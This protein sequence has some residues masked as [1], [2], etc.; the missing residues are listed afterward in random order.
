MLLRTRLAW[1]AA[2]V[3]AVVPS[4]GPR[5]AAAPTVA[6]PLP[7]VAWR[8]VGPF[9]G[10]WSTM[11][12]GVPGL[13]DTYYAGTAGGGLWKSND[14]GR[15]WRA[16]SD[17]A[18]ITAVGALA[19][20][21]SDPSTLY[22]GTGQPEPRYDIGA[23][24]G[25]Y[26]SRDAGTSWESMGLKD[27]R[28]IGAL[29]VDRRD[30]NV[31]LV[32]ALGHAFGPGG[33]RG[34]YRSGD[35]GKSWERTLFVDDQTGA[36]DLA[37]D[38]LDPDLVFAATW[39]MRVWPWLSYFTPVE[40]PG[41][42]IYRSRDGGRTWQKLGGAGW[43]EGDLGR[44][45][46]AVTR[47]AGATRIYAAV[48]SNKHAGLYRSDD[49]GGHWT[50]VNDAAWATSW[51]V[52]RVTVSP[53]DPDDVFLPG[54]SIHES[55]DGG[56]TFTIVRGAPGG[57]DFHFLWINPRDPARRIAASDQGAIVT[58]NGGETWSDWYNQP[59]GQFYHLAIDRVFPY[60]IYSGQQDSG[61]VRIAS[62]SND[63]AIGERDWR[64]VGAEERDYDLPDPE[65]PAIVFGSGLGG[66]ITRWDE[67]TGEAANVSPWPL[68]SYGKRPTDYR[69]HYNWFTPIAFSSQPPYALYA[70][71][72]ALFRS[73]DRGQ[74]WQ[75]VS[76]DLSGH[77]PGE[78]DCSGSPEPA[79]ALACGFGVINTIAPSPRDRA[80][81]WVGTDDGLVWLTRDDARSWARVTPPGVPPWAKVSS[82]DLPPDR[83]GTAYV[84]VDNHRQD[85]VRPY[86]YR[87]GDYGASWI[88]IGAGLPAGHF[89]SVVRADPKRAGLLYA[90]TELGVEVSFDDGA[91]WEALNT[92]LP[93]VWVHDLAVHDQD[94][95]AATNGRAIWVL[96][97]LS[98]L[99]QRALAASGAPRLYAPSPAYRLRP[100]TYSDTPPP[101]ETPLARNP[102]T[103]AVIDYLLPEGAHGV[104]ALEIRDS[105]GALV[106]RFASDA[107]AEDVQAQ[108]Y[109][110]AD[111][112]KP[113]PRPSAGA[114]PHRFIWNLRYPRPR[115]IQY[116][117]GTVA[118]FA[119]G[120][121]PA[122]GG[123]LVLPGEY[124]LALVVDG[125][126]LEAPLTVLA[127]PR[128]TVTPDALAAGVEFWHSLVP[129]LERAWRGFAEIGAVRIALAARRKA[130]ASGAPHPAL[131]ARLATLD[132]ALAAL[133]SGKQ[134]AA[135]NLA[136]DDEV[137][138]RLASDVES[139]DRAPTEAQRE[140]AA[141]SVAGID[142]V[143]H[144]WAQ[145][146]AGELAAV[147]RLL[148][149]ARLQP[150]RVPPAAEL[151]SAAP[152]AGSD[153]E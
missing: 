111:W 52:S 45:G 82:I 84:V 137:L 117:Y 62:R 66:R 118:T 87:T 27:T 43:P 49:G 102:P 76:A 93:P 50:R 83:P 21:P 130:I 104:V 144:N 2:M 133:V 75:V 152:S 126:R 80:E 9:R 125:R 51:Y 108:V 13:P 73:L 36:V 42:A 68:S 24:S 89:V 40:G 135:P 41:S 55:K 7:A 119:E 115:A 10:G 145:L 5:A 59:T 92:N 122:P 121:D 54:Q 16:V 129:V 4:P 15:S 136:A 146:R 26:R 63:G 8:L 134:K 127:D 105:R 103:G 90:G 141:Q 85:D 70:G 6:E 120:A 60:R 57:D 98:P 31:V 32:A 143:L 149:A 61:T 113:A 132:A 30:A 109:F 14:S 153:Q 65:D 38:P 12:V 34:V 79:R 20:A 142:V 116:Q 150:L 1:L 44:I 58:V 99:R 139:A 71:A 23:G 29:L 11:A 140:V 112:L 97:D 106:R 138:A 94:L 25:V 114:G 148:A 107:A 128:L 101:P 19:V 67:R 151:R 88:A 81:I 48:A 28:H 53:V 100:N 86:V 72:Q 22:V 110:T 18:P 37:V 35:G 64:P 77:A 56:R 46:L 147:N 47:A 96:D 91:T 124:R 123:A 69:Y 39:T 74:H 33:E 131:D 17:G 78:H 95:V 3:A